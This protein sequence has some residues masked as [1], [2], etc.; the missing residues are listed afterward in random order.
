VF[1][2]V[3]GLIFLIYFA[4]I[5]FM[6]EVDLQTSIALLV[7][8]ALT[9]GFLLIALGFYLLAPG[10]WWV[11]V[12][13]HQV[14]RNFKK[15]Q[16]H[17]TTD[18]VPRPKGIARCRRQSLYSG[19]IPWAFVLGIAITS[20]AANRSDAQPYSQTQIEGLL[21]AFHSSDPNIR[22]ATIESLREIGAAAVPTLI[23]A[24]SSANPEI[25]RGAVEALGEFGPLIADQTVPPLVNALGDAE[26]MVR[27]EV[28]VAFGRIGPAGAPALIEALSNPDPK[29]RQA[30][31][32]ALGRIGAS[33]ADTT[34]PPLI[35]ALGD[36][37][38]EVRT[39]ASW[40]L[41]QIGQPAVSAL[42]SALSAPDPKVR[43]AA[44]MALGQMGPA[45]AS[46]LQEHGATVIAVL[47]ASLDGTSY[48]SSREIIHA[49]TQIG[50]AAAPALTTALDDK[51]PDVRRGAVKALG[52][53]GQA[54]FASVVLPALITALNN[55]DER[56]RGEAAEVI[57]WIAD[58]AAEAVP[59]L[60][61]MLGGTDSW[62]RERVMTTLGFI[63]PAAVPALI[64]ALNSTNPEVRHDA[65]RV[66]GLIRPPATQAIP[67]LI[68]GLD[69]AGFRVRE[70]AAESLQ[71]IGAPAVPALIAALSNPNPETRR[72]AAVALG[73]IRDQA[74]IPALV[75]ALWD[76][77]SMVRQAAST[78]LNEIPKLRV[79]YATA[80]PPG[81]PDPID[82]GLRQSIFQL[83]IQRA[84]AERTPGQLLF[85]PPTRMKLGVGERIT[86]RIGRGALEEDLKRDLVRRGLAQV[87]TIK[88]GTLMRVELSGPDFQTA[89]I[90]G[91]R[92][93][94]IPEGEMEEWQFHVFP[95][96][97]GPR[98]ILD[99][100]VSIRIRLPSSEELPGSL[101]V[102]RAEYPA[103]EELHSFPSFHREIAVDVN[104]PFYVQRFLGEHWQ[105]FAGGFGAVAVSV[106]G[107]F[108]KRWLDSRAS[109]P[110][111]RSRTRSQGRR[112]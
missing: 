92:D 68:M 64:A 75:D 31:T 28:T 24:L 37:D 58:A 79:A 45:A 89:L 17:R 70:Q 67:A 65:A 111:P 26:V 76:S 85:N 88:V 18:E 73:Q 46:A 87:E 38:S 77:E 84:M 97:A 43:Q 50:P 61:T 82:P 103:K 13:R 16:M 55:S 15:P 106:I 3:G 62:D 69:D 1:L 109:R 90:N 102:L 66:L 27:K 23:A 100:L 78:A 44:G 83:A 41:A 110:S 5:G 63:G 21:E 35:D 47:I 81:T 93:R 36:V 40:A 86:V 101:G 98:R 80:P 14:D 20:T 71:W 95:L 107:F 51:S 91:D 56:V 112:R 6:P 8:S 53:L 105:F 99:L 96:K 42:A 25:R 49:L 2:F 19:L 33:A 108:G 52:R 12:T 11:Q 4:S 60:I 104:L 57:G 48:D 94:I 72:V 29:V 34:V 9:G 7:V 10:W 22:K 59:A 30:T 39:Y 54:G 74:A 32:V